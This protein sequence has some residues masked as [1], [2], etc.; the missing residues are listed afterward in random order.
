MKWI[1]VLLVFLLAACAPA[2]A[3]PEI[4]ETGD[5]VVNLEGT[6]WELESMGQRGA[7]SPIVVG[8]TVTL[9]F[10]AEGMVVGQGGCNGYG[11]QY[12]V[13][14]ENI[15]I[16]EIVSTLMACADDA[17]TQQEADFFQALQAADTYE[18]EGDRLTIFYN[19]GQEALVF[20]R[21]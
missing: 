1:I 7:E 8:S 14:G 15:E 3:T 17:V 9:E 13:D 5:D 20:S 16:R 10:Q 4:P 11:G 12:T 19:D 18:V 2:A 21:M 6:R